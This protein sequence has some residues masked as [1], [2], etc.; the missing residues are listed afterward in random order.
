MGLYSNDSGTLNPIAGTPDAQLQRIESDLTGKQDK[1]LSSSVAIGSQTVTTVEGAIDGV[2]DIVPASAS[3]ANQLA[4]ASD[5]P[6]VDST[7]SSTSTNPVENRAVKTAI[8]AKA[9]S[10]TTLAGYGIANAYTKDEIDQLFSEHENNISWKAAVATYAD[11]LTTYPNPEE[12]WTVV[13]TDT[14]IAWRYSGGAWVQISANTI[15]IA[16]SSVDGL[17]STHMFD[18]LDGIATGAEVNQNAFSNVKVGNIVVAAD[19]KTDTVELAAGSNVTLTPDATNDKITISAANTTYAV[20]TAASGSTVPSLVTAGDK[21]NWNNKLDDSD[22]ED[23]IRSEVQETIGQPSIETYLTGQYFF[24]T[25]GLMYKAIDDIDSGDTLVLNTNCAKTSIP[26]ELMLSRIFDSNCGVHLTSGDLNDCLEPRNYWFGQ[27][28]A[29]NIS[30]APVANQAFFIMVLRVARHQEDFTQIALMRDAHRIFIRRYYNSGSWSD[31]TEFIS[32]LGGQ[33]LDSSIYYKYTDVDLKQSDNGVS[34]DT[35]RFP[36]IVRDSGDLAHAVLCVGALT[37]GRTTWQMK[38]RNFDSSGDLLGNKG[39]TLYMDKSGTLTY[40]L[41]H[42]S[43]FSAALGNGYGICSTAA[44]TIAKEVSIDRYT[45]ASNGR[46]TVRFVNDVPANSTLNINSTGARPI[47]YKNAAITDGVLKGG[48]IATFILITGT[49]WVLMCIDR[50]FLKYGGEITGTLTTKYNEIDTK[51]A[52]NNVPSASTFA[53]MDS[54]QVVDKNSLPMTAFRTYAY[55]EGM[56]TSNWAVFNTNSSGQSVGGNQLVLRMDKTGTIEYAVNDAWR[57]RGALGMGYADCTTA[58]STLAKEVT[59]DNY[60][61]SHNALVAIRF[62]Y[63]VPANSTLNISNRGAKAI[64]YR[65]HAL[66][67][68]YIRGG[69]KCLFLYDGVNYNLIAKDNGISRMNFLSSTDLTWVGI[70]P[71]SAGVTMSAYIPNYNMLWLEMQMSVKDAVTVN[72]N[73][74]FVYFTG[75][76]VAWGASHFFINVSDSQVIPAYAYSHGNTGVELRLCKQVAFT[77]G[78]PLRFSVLIYGDTLF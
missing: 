55:N 27:A 39:I 21:Y 30:N 23:V 13:T 42:A 64:K 78:Q 46:V 60:Y 38:L 8:D 14:N 37:D 68:G 54:S 25:N 40:Y 47:Y 1:N 49:T 16:T 50:S 11:I 77:A 33:V 36:L 24:D 41:D 6:D 7:L 67:S 76:F 56:V 17:M 2:S 9:D 29:A 59:I 52:N 53:Y 3:T 32:S 44:S 61:P 72:A 75:P 69:D 26:N 34:E 65:D 74:A 5:I 10:A 31:W 4:T 57:F 35:Y 22:I 20:E 15:P 28:D 58:E 12:G 43:H 45:L 51:L 48:D 63:N 70:Q 66:P 18:K 19:S 62:K 73:T 71:T